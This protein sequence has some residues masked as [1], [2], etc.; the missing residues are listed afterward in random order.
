MRGAQSSTEGS[1]LVGV[2]SDHEVL[3]SPVIAAAEDQFAERLHSSQISALIQFKL[4]K[5]MTF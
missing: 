2:V 4:F 5:S 3:A 1:M